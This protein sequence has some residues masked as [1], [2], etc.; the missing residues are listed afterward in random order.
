[1]KIRILTRRWKKTD[2]AEHFCDERQQKSRREIIFYAADVF[3]KR[4]KGTPQG[5][6]DKRRA[7]IM[8]EQDFRGPDPRR[9][10]I[11]NV[12]FSTTGIPL[13][14]L[15]LYSKLEEC[16]QNDIGLDIFVNTPINVEM[17]ALGIKVP[18]LLRLFG[19]LIRNAIQSIV[20]TAGTER[21][22]LLLITYNEQ[23]QLE[24][25]VFDSGVPV[26]GQPDEAPET[27]GGME[28]DLADI[29]EILADTGAS[30]EV[31]ALTNEYD[32]FTKQVCIRF[33]QKAERSPDKSI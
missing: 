16:R 22:I 5:V 15:M 31:A 30:I 4:I 12:I 18:E 29:A 26:C 11:S 19:D 24:F 33:D 20:K 14:D 32:I 28:N 2:F 17:Q 23:H 10:D 1:M 13:L 3:R 9:E 21:S 7:E 8:R 6:P 27:G 25:Q